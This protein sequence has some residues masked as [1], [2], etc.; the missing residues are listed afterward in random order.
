MGDNR[1]AQENPLYSG[2]R[3]FKATTKGKR[4]PHLCLAQEPDLA[5]VLRVAPLADS[6]VCLP[7]LPYPN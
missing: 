3:T 5:R 7:Y 1:R 2:A 4:R 6:L